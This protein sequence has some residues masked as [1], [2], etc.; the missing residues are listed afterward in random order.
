[1]ESLGSELTKS[2]LVM[3]LG[4]Y[5]FIV[6][7]IATSSTRGN[8]TFSHYYLPCYMFGLVMLAGLVAYLERRRPRWIV[9]YLGLALIVSIY[10]APVWGEFPMTTAAANRRLFIPSWRP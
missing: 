6:P 1:M 3:L 10:Y 9:N 5:S 8:Y 7:W 4:W 2:I